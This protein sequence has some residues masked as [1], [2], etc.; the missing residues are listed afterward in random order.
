MTDA[1][2]AEAEAGAAEEI[3]SYY[4]G[5]PAPLPDGVRPPDDAELRAAD[6]MDW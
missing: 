6:E 5:R 2:R 3:R 1:E 4:E